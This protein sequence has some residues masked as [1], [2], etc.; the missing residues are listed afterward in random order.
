MNP[1]EKNIFELF[2]HGDEKAFESIFKSYYNYLFNYSN[3][4]LKNAVAAEDIVE[5]TFINFWENRNNI[6]LETSVKS[7]L[8]KS[9]FNNCLNYIKHLQV[10]E[11]YELYFKHHIETDDSGNIISDNYPLSQLIEKEQDLILELAL[12]DLPDHCRKV[13]LL[14]RYENLKNEEIAVKL[15]I[16]VNTVRTQ[17][18]RALHKL[19]VQLQEYLPVFTIIGFILNYLTR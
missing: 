6:L 3:Q 10:M 17:I 7:Y 11:R 8:F 14:S 9:A 4:I 5:I 19:R 2:Q 13:F 12:K 16:S 1:L 15:N 18:S